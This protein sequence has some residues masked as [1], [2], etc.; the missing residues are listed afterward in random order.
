MFR[1]SKPSQKSKSLSRRRAER[2]LLFW[3]IRESLKLTAY[4]M[5]LIYAVVY[6]MIAVISGEVTSPDK[7]LPLR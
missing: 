3:T 2:E 6:L 4:A 7:F 1:R 5:F